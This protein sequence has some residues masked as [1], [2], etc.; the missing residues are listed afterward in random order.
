MINRIQSLK[1]LA[2]AVVA[3]TGFGPEQATAANPPVSQA[4]LVVSHGI[5]E[6]NVVKLNAKKLEKWMV[7]QASH[8]AEADMPE[9]R[10]LI[11]KLSGSSSGDLVDRVNRTINDV[12]YVA[13]TADEWQSPGAFLRRGGDC[14]DYAIAKYMALRA[15]GVPAA[16]MRVLALPP[17]QK[18]LAHA[19]LTVETSQGWM[20]L[21][22][23]EPE[24]YP[25]TRS[26]ARTYVFGVN[27]TVW[28]VNLG[29][30]DRV[31]SAE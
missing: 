29:A 22:N 28:W 15:L 19:I 17:T 27:D 10:G 6:S 25:L 4:V 31:A 26:I 21:D 2:V 16:K 20:V 24:I 3:F 30:R 13:E 9:W 18:R 23:L 11:A 8:R 14:E 1:W 7:V 12:R 5:D